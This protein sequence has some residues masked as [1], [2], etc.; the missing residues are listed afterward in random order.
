MIRFILRRLAFA[1]PTLLVGMTLIFFA[2]NIIPGDPATLLLGDYY[3]GEAYDALVKQMGL[4]QPLHMRYLWFMGDTLRG[5]LGTSFRTGRTVLSDIAAQFPYTLTLALASL[6]IAVVTGVTVGI[7]SAMT[8]NRWPDQIAMLAA[9]SS[10]ST[11]S[12]FF[13]VL[14][15]LVFS[16]YLGWL[17]ALGAG[18]FSEPGSVLLHLILPAFALGLRSAAMIA[19]L[20]RSAVIEI[21]NQDYIR[22]AQAKGLAQRTVLLHHA[23]RNATLPLIT[24]IGLDLGALLGGTTIIEIVFNRPGMGKLLVDGVLNRDYPTVQGTII[25]FMILI[26]LSNLLADIG[27][28]LA[29][30]RIRFD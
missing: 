13:G 10:I 4:D 25:F 22:T 11:P 15:I 8:R 9:L 18:D 26:L 17:P 3:T 20:T 1:I 14:L 29:D 23:L 19:R 12:F 21:L 27:Y 2:I 7:I 5:D 24:I 6:L 30:P 16:V 28:G